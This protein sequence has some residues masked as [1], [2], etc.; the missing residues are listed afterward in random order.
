MPEVI[1]EPELGEEGVEIE[2]EELPVLEEPEATEQTQEPQE[3]GPSPT[4]PESGTVV[5][6]GE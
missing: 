2:G 1:E 3:V 4:V 6:E 5:I